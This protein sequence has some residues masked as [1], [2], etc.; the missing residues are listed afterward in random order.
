MQKVKRPGNAE[1]VTKASRMKKIVM[2]SNTP[3]HRNWQLVAHSMIFIESIATIET[4]S[5]LGPTAQAGSIPVGLLQEEREQDAAHNHE[6]AVKQAIVFLLLSLEV[7][8]GACT[9]VQQQ[10]AHE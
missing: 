9:D 5:A 10:A 4:T 6:A 1:Y 7:S 2:A 3:D 8:L